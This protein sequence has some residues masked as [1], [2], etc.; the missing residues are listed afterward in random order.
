MPLKNQMVKQTGTTESYS[1]LKRNSLFI[2]RTTL[3]DLKVITLNVENQPIRSH[4]GMI[5]I[6]E[7]TKLYR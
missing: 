1:T 4:Y 5:N 7:M 6:L 2:H 3:M